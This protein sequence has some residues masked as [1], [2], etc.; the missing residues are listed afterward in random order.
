M[1]SHRVEYI[2][3]GGGVTI[4]SPLLEVILLVGAIYVVRPLWTGAGTMLN[5]EYFFESVCPTVQHIR[6]AVFRLDHALYP[7]LRGRLGEWCDTEDAFIK[8]FTDLWIRGILTHTD[9]FALLAM[10]THTTLGALLVVLAISPLLATPYAILAT[11]VRL[12]ETLIIP[13]WSLIR[14]VARIVRGVCFLV[15]FPCRVAG[16]CCR[17]TTLG[18]VVDN[19]FKQYFHRRV[20]IPPKTGDKKR[21]VESRGFVDI[22]PFGILSRVSR[23]FFYFHQKA[24]RAIIATIVTLVFLSISTRITLLSLPR[25]GNGLL[26]KYAEQ[27]MW[28]VLTNGNEPPP[29]CVS[30]DKLARKFSERLGI[31]IPEFESLGDEGRVLA[32]MQHSTENDYIDET[33]QRAFR[34][35]LGRFMDAPIW[36][37]VTLMLMI[38]LVVFAGLFRRIMFWLDLNQRHRYRYM[39]SRLAEATQSMRHK[40]T[41]SNLLGEEEDWSF[42]DKETDD[43]T[44][45]TSGEG[46]HDFSTNE[47]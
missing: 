44:E 18:L 45:F 36:Y 14:L 24:R 23:I 16:W 13:N 42:S 5:V 29:R 21:P 19:D 41:S 43:E 3:D 11:V 12:I 2:V 35:M 15:W 28:S 7:V 37:R 31:V 20:K 32:K 47:W 9:S 17:S 1:C 22:S 6:R 26:S 30:V 33:L 27:E 4:L 39:R 8:I 25:C 38:G 40:D 10:K 46:K 34:G